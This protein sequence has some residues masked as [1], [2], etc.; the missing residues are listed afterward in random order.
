MAVIQRTLCQED[1]REGKLC[2]SP[3]NVKDTTQQE[4]KEAREGSKGSLI[5]RFNVNEMRRSVK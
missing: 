5:V 1:E 2:A 4:R 3:V